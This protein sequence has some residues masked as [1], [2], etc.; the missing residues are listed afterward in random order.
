MEAAQENQL[1]MPSVSVPFLRSFQHVESKRGLP[2]TEWFVVHVSIRR[3]SAIL[4]KLAYKSGFIYEEDQ[5]FFLI[6]TSRVRDQ[7][8]RSATLT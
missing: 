6:F 1:V 2:S 3:G 8:L 4:G 5:N 7:T